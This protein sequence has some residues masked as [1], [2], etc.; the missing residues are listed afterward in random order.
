MM[1]AAR[2]LGRP[3]LARRARLAGD[4]RPLNHIY[5]GLGLTGSSSGSPLDSEGH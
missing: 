2:R 4:V 5:S 1:G 3:Q